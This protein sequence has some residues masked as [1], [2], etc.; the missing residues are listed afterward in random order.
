MRSRSRLLSALLLLSSLLAVTAAA[1]PAFARTHDA[2][3]STLHIVINDIK[4]LA[5]VATSTLVVTGT[6]T[7]MGATPV[8]ALTVA[9]ND[10]GEAFS[11]ADL[12]AFRVAPVMGS[13]RLTVTKPLKRLAIGASSPF[14]LSVPSLGQVL[15]DPFRVYKLAVVASGTS[16]TSGAA[17]SA[18]PLGVT[19][20]PL[21]YFPTQVLS[22]L[23][24]ALIIPMT[25]VPDQGPVPLPGAGSPSS[26]L[27]SS[28]SG[29]RLDHLLAAVEAAPASGGFGG[30]QLTLALDPALL[31]RVCALAGR[32]DQHTVGGESS[33]DIATAGAWLSRLFTAVESP[34]VTVVGLPYADADIGR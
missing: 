21:P 22:P 24:T 30:T 3:P 7:N 9:L 31:V 17:G 15:T 2:A 5:P 18:A 12:D 26:D 20:L 6:V 13:T 4:P 23:R 27:I 10:A 11:K 29:G 16:G 8:S 14:T 25:A 28:L 32:C 1:R 19:G 33:A 34:D